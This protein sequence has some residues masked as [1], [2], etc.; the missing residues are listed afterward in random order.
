MYRPA[1]WFVIFLFVGLSCGCGKKKDTTFL[2]P[3]TAGMAIVT[4]ADEE[5][6]RLSP[7]DGVVL[8]QVMNWLD[9]DISRRLR[10]RGFEIALL[11]DMKSYTSS[12]GSL[13]IIHIDS[14]EPGLAANLPH[15]EASGLPS[16][17]I[18]NYRLL[19]ERGALLDQWQDGAE[20]IKGG[21]YCAR[22]LNRRAM[23]KIAAAFQEH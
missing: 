15:R 6:Q 19:D 4:V 21:T 2:P 9:R 16:A 18:V 7:D 22:T 13:L 11:R 12:M 3:Q 1:V 10:D 5:R 23:E 17:L 14:F 20:S 8:L